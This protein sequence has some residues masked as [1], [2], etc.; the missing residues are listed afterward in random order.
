[1]MFLLDSFLKYFYNS[2]METIPNLR[3]RLSYLRVYAWYWIHLKY[4]LAEIYSESP[5]VKEKPMDLL[6]EEAILT[7]KITSA[8]ISA[9]LLNLIEGENMDYR[10]V[11]S[12]LEV[13]NAVQ[14]PL[15]LLNPLNP[16]GIPTHRLFLKIGILILLQ[17]NLCPPKLCNE[18]RLHV[19]PVQKNVIEA[20]IITGSAKG[21]SAFIPRIPLMPS[22]YPFQFKRIQFPIKACFAMKINK[23]HQQ[24]LKVAGIDL[25]EDCFSHRQLYVACSRVSSPS[26]LVILAPGRRTIKVVYKEVLK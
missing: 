18:T 23:L 14:C 4:L 13:D 19:T 24:S 22:D 20:T 6:C 12:V 9:I 17:R 10:S 5:H 15:E 25:R 2:D 8:E 21:E 11:D 3:E 1:M 26:S 7:K 16:P